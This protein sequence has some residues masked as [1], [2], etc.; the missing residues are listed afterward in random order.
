ML[1]ETKY[2]PSAFG[3]WYFSIVN[4][5]MHIYSWALMPTVPSFQICY[6]ESTQSFWHKVVVVVNV[7][8]VQKDVYSLQRGVI[9]KGNFMNGFV[10]NE[11][12]KEM[13][14]VKRPSI[15]QNPCKQ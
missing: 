4:P 10:V 5:P 11:A 14:H 6:C 2:T 7:G 12:M 8:V 15:C 13:K 1:K 3:L 9:K